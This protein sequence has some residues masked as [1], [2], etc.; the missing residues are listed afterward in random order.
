MF[1]HSSLD[2]FAMT[3]HRQP[4]KDVAARCENNAIKG[5]SM[6]VGKRLVSFFFVC[7]FCL[8]EVYHPAAIVETVS[9]GI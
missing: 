7:F 1:P 8:H 5:L 3:L 9:N 4:C 6:V 2:A